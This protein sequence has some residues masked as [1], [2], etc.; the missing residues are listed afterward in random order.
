MSQSRLFENLLKIHKNAAPRLSVKVDFKKA[1]TIV[2]IYPNKLV[3]FLDDLLKSFDE[4]LINYVEKIGGEKD[5]L[6][7]SVILAK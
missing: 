7:S 3:E 4:K 5:P 1:A 2:G 6:K